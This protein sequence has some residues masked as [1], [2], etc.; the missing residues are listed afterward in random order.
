MDPVTEWPVAQYDGPLGTTTQRERGWNGYSGTVPILGP[1]EEACQVC[2]RT[3]RAHP[4]R[5]R[6][7]G[8][9]VQCW[10]FL[11]WEDHRDRQAA[12]VIADVRTS[13]TCHAC[14]HDSDVE[15]EG[16]VFSWMECT[17]GEH[18]DRLGELGAGCGASSY[19][20]M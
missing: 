1:V 15:G 6:G 4:V 18:L 9:L 14:G 12:T 5:G 17:C 8:A 20:V 19:L 3:P 7:Y 2:G 16:A 13:W 10:A 11:G